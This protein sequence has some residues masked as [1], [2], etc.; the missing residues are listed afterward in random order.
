MASPKFEVLEQTNI[1]VDDID[2]LVTAMPATRGLMFI[3]KHQEAIDAGKADLSQM[4]QI[5][6]N[7]VS[8]DNL[9]ITEKSFDIQFARKYAHLNKLYKEVLNFNFEELFQAPDTEE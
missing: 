4:K 6:C 9:Q 2:Y 1:T 5:I 7:Y 3:E 8:K